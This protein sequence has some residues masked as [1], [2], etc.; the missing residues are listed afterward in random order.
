ME[1]NFLHNPVHFKL[2]LDLSQ[3]PTF[4]FR[5]FLQVS[6]HDILCMH[7]EWTN[8]Q[9]AG[10]VV[11][12]HLSPSVRSKVHYLFQADWIFWGFC[13]LEAYQLIHIQPPCCFYLEVQW[14]CVH[15]LSPVDLIDFLGN[16]SQLVTLYQLSSRAFFIAN[17]GLFLLWGAR[18]CLELSSVGQCA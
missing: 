9:L 11:S 18:F 14:I 15:N 10:M 1:L 4:S 12:G 8:A 16:A 3:L 7:Q 5:T 2:T 13:G 17:L 6:I